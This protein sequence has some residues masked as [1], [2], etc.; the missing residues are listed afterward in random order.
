MTFPNSPD[1][2]SGGVQ[3]GVEI[4]MDGSE[5]K[6]LLIAAKRAILKQIP[7]LLTNQGETIAEQVLQLSQAYVTLVLG[8]MPLIIPPDKAP[9]NPF[10]Y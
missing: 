9:F 1:A 5:E 6:L 3:P 7:K 8:P 4:S 10:G 2:S